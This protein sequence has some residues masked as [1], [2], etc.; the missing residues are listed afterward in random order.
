MI[1]ISIVDEHRADAEALESY[2]AQHLN[3][4]GIPHLIHRYSR[5]V[6]FIRSRTVYNI[7]FMD[8]QLGDMD[9][10]DAARFLRIVNKDAKLIFT[11]K[12]PQL[13]IYGYEA[14]ALDFMVK[15]LD[16]VT[17][18]RVLDKALKGIDLIACEHFALKTPG[19]LVRMSTGNIYYVEVFD[20][21]LVYH[22]ELGDYRA[23]GKLGMVWQ[24]LENCLFLQC[25]RSYL[26]NM[27]HVQSLHND[28]LVVNGTK[29]QIAKSRQ[30]QIEQQFIDYVGACM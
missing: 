15:P 16:G 25:S 5:G 24:R 3:H 30:K 14:Q 26:V 27:R 10:L 20:H 17:V 22:T 1:L 23:R 12:E 4:A 2:I 11:S 21:D 28:H 18:A 9:G 19:G 6:D 13:A 7:V 8:I 29:I